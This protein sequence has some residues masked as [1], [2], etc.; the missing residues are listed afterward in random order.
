MAG[1]DCCYEVSL[2]ALIAVRHLDDGSL[3]LKERFGQAAERVSVFQRVTNALDAEH[4]RVLSG[5][6]G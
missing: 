2:D 5:S 3:A 1:T 6:D 4:G